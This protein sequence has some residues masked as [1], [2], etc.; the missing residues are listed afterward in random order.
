MNDPRIG[1]IGPVTKDIEGT[2]FNIFQKT[3]R[4]WDRIHPYNAAQ[5]MELVGDFPPKQ[6]EDAFNA[7]ISDLGLGDFLTDGP[8]YMIAPHG[9]PLT[10]EAFD[11]T[12]ETLL[13]REMNRPFDVVR[14]AP[15]RP[16][17]L[18]EAGRRIVGLTY[19]H[20][21]ADSVSIR[22]LMRQWLLRLTGGGGPAPV[23]LPTA[24][25]LKTFGPGSAGWSVTAQASSLIGFQS[26]M[27]MMR[28]VESKSD[29]S[30]AV[31]VRDGP[32]G[33]I[34]AIKPRAKA[35]G[36]TVGDVF[37]AAATAA[38]DAVGPG[39][40]SSRRP[41]LAM[42]TIVDL[43][44]RG[45]LRKDNPSANVFGLFL[46]FTMTP[47]AAAD[48]A[49]FDR[50]LSRAVLARRSSL[51]RHAA[52]ASQLNITIGYAIGK[53]LG[54]TKLRE[55]YRKR[56][57]LTG[58]LSSVNMTPGWAGEHHPLPL[59][60]Y[61]R[62]SPTGPMLP[63]VLTPT[64]LGKT[65]RVCCTYRSALMDAQRASKLTDHFLQTLVRFAG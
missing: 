46:G 17:D 33:L 18:T 22:M 42:G 15:F 53:W 55:F 28:R 11:D 45:C 52:E 38:C 37:L 29:A 2:R 6:V 8:T 34:D 27:K 10:V 16:F 65:L 13:T 19:Q 60:A 61:H 21:I 7:A 1:S 31:L 26:R 62:V 50:L 56:F 58:G 24:G 35:A 23:K 39:H 5:A 49:T 41:D 54:P 59:A 44:A 14:T 9:A 32:D 25:L 30:V 48:T 20:W 3:Q 36:A 63:L 64:T 4:L 43:R 40:P 51:A 12:F 57:P 47:F